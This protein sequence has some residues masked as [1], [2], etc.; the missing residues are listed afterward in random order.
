[1]YLLSIWVDQVVWPFVINRWKF[2]QCTDFLSII[3]IIITHADLEK[4]GYVE[5]VDCIVVT[6]KGSGPLA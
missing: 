3:I 5:H 1:M 6:N 2:H 4:I